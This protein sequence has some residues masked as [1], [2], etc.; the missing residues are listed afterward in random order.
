MNSL[1]SLELKNKNIVLRV[2]L[3]VPIQDGK[4]LDRTRIDAVRPT[5]DFLLSQDSRILLISH[6]GRP[7]EGNLESKYSLRPIKE[8]FE[9]IYN[10]KI[11]LFNDLEAKEIFQGKG[12]IQFLENIRSFN[13]ESSNCSKLSNKLGT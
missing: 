11:D 9:K 13:G 6:L 3:N 7:T 5:I 10:T 4:I 1:N 12:K 8:E 2:D